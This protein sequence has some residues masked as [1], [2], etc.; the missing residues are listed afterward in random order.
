MECS[1]IDET[2]KEKIEIRLKELAGM[3]YR[4]LGVGR[5]MMEGEL[6]QEQ[7]KIAFEFLGLVA[8]SD[9]PKKNITEV[10]RS[11]REAGISVKLITGDY[12]ET[13]G[14]IARLTGISDSGKLLTG[15]QMESMNDHELSTE[16]RS[17]DVF[18][19]VSPEAK[20]RIVELLKNQGEVVAMTGD[21]V[22][23]GPALK[24]AHIGIAMG[25]RGS[26]VAR[27]A[28]SLILVNDDLGNMVK[29]VALGRKIYF[30]LKKAIR[31]IISIHIPLISIVTLPLLLGWKFP[32]LF[33]PVHVIF[34]ELLMGPT[35]SI[36]YENEPM[37]KGLMNKPPRKLSST[38]FTWSELS[39]SILQGV[40]ITLSLMLL[41]Y[42]CISQEYSE[43]FTRTTIFTTLILA[44]ILLTLTGRS[45]RYSIFTTIRYKN[46]LV[47]VIITLTISMLALLLW[48][49]PASALFGLTAPDTRQLLI[50]SAVAALSVIWIEAYK[51]VQKKA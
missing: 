2:T 22:N 39:T 18:A 13:A 40:A 36:V 3:G 4:V 31:Y 44:N 17:T 6:P 51:M 37:E 50:S 45:D 41:L 25:V 21:G 38:F 27:Q 47:P 29:A 15:K 1:G 7:Q 32:N 35:C 10:I 43:T 12:P 42:Y 9:P 19:R 34:L 33:S 8:F 5:S 23:D 48:Y 16:L 20:L 11:F 30:N 28:A 26:E 49:S 46:R 24:A 14:T